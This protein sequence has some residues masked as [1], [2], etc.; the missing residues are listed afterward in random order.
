MENLPGMTETAIAI[1]SILILLGGGVIGIIL[2][3]IHS[4]DPRSRPM[5]VP[6]K[7]TDRS[8]W[9]AG[10]LA[11]IALFALWTWT[12]AGDRR[13]LRADAAPANAYKPKPKPR[14]IVSLKDCPPPSPGMTD[15]VVMVIKS[16]A[17]MKPIVARCSRIA[18]RAFILKSRKPLIAEAK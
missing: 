18:E 16:Q 17:D 15:L 10:I 7:S 4:A 5:A 13:A 14:Q 2:H 8:A 11:A 9:G 6:N 3:L 12:D 1:W